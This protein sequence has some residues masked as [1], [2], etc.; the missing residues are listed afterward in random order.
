MPH[1]K[2]RPRRGKLATPWPPRGG[3]LCLTRSGLHVA[4]GRSVTFASRTA[5]NSFELNSSSTASLS[6][7]EE[8]YLATVFADA[9]PR[10]ASASEVDVA[11][12]RDNS[13]RRRALSADST[14]LV[15]FTFNVRVMEMR[16]GGKGSVIVGLWAGGREGV[17]GC[18]GV[19][20]LGHDRG[21]WRENELQGEAQAGVVVAWCASGAGFRVG[22][23]RTHSLVARPLTTTLRSHPRS[24]IWLSSR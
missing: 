18:G 3:A 8:T 15:N 14:F 19:S 24:W 1:T 12:A 13:R 9:S 22:R 21:R 4:D 10:V 17:R 2:C 5:N 11:G 20:V 23:K 6:S 7:A 16:K